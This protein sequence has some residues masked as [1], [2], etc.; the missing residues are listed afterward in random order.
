[1]SLAWLFRRKPPLV[2][3]YERLRIDAEKAALPDLLRSLTRLAKQLG[4][5]KLEKWAR[6][7]LEGYENTNPAMT[8]DVVVPEYRTVPGQWADEFGNV[9]LLQDPGLQFLNEQRL[10]NSIVDLEQL[11]HSNHPLYFRAPRGSQMI[12]KHLQVEVSRFC[13]SSR[14][15]VT[16]LAAIRTRLIERLDELQPVVERAAKPS[17]P[18]PIPSLDKITSMSSIADRDALAHHARRIHQSLETDPAQAI[19]SSK[20]LVET[21]AKHVLQHSGEDLRSYDTFP[22]LVKAAIKKLALESEPLPDAGKG[23]QAIAMLTGGLGQAAEAV[24]TLRNLYGTGH[25][26]ARPSGA[27]SRHARLIVGACTTL[28]A[29]LLETL[30]A[31][32]DGRS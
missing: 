30:E 2:H 23:A 22:K 17:L 15:L 12:G 24:A 18:T 5:E 27:E 4:E 8:E 29:F 16:V 20:E 7:E 25:G 21:V 31:R 10:R 9:L 3:A 6:L 11:A 1:M 13:F 28:A 14:S 32:R 26:H 19:G